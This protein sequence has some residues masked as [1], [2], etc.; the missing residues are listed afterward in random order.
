M[1]KEQILAH[2]K[3]RSSNDGAGL[4]AGL[5]GR[6]FREVFRAV[7]TAANGLR[8][9]FSLCELRLTAIDRQWLC[10]WPAQVSAAALEAALRD[11]G[12]DEGVVPFEAVGLLLLLVATEVGRQFAVSGEIWPVLYERFSRQ[13]AGVIFAGKHPRQVVREAIEAACRRLGLRHAFGI[14]GTQ[15]YYLTIYLQF[16]FGQ[17]SLAKLPL[18][19]ESGQSRPRSVELL[20][21]SSGEFQ[22]LWKALE[23]WV[24][25]RAGPHETEVIRSSPFIPEE[26]ILVLGTGSVPVLQQGFCFCWEGGSI[27]ELL[28]DLGRLYPD[29]ED[30][31]Y[32]VTRLDEQQ[33]VTR[34]NGKFE[35]S[36]LRFVLAASEET[37]VLDPLDASSAAQSECLRLWDTDESYIFLDPARGMVLRRM[38][39]GPFWLLTSPGYRSTIGHS[40][41]SSLEDDWRI[42]EFPSPP[43][44]RFLDGPDGPIDFE[45]TPQQSPLSAADLGIMAH[46]VLT[47][48]D[49]IQVAVTSLK[50][51]AKDCRFAFRGR[52][53][54]AELTLGFPVLDIELPLDLPS[55]E[56]KL[57]IHARANGRACM[58]TVS[59]ALP[60]LAATWRDRGIWKAL[61]GVGEIEADEMIRSPVRLF[62]NKGFYAL[63]EGSTLSH[64]VR[65]GEQFLKQLAGLGRPLMLRS[66]PFHPLE[67]NIVLA[68][69]VVHRGRLRKI[70][71][72]GERFRL[73]LARPLQDDPELFLLW[74]D[75]GDTVIR[76]TLEGFL[77]SKE[78]IEG[79]VPDEL[80]DRPFA[81]ALGFQ[82]ARLGVSWSNTLAPP[83]QANW[84][85]VAH[86]LRWMQ[87]PFLA[88]TWWS[89][90]GRAL[91]ENWWV[92]LNAWLSGLRFQLL[93]VLLEAPERQEF[94]EAIVRLVHRIE[95]DASESERLLQG[96][97]LTQWIRCAPRFVT[98]ML[99]NAPASS[100]RASLF[101][102]FKAQ[103]MRDLDPLR[104]TAHRSL[105]ADE[106]F[107]D[108]LVESFCQDKDDSSLSLALTQTTFAKLAVASWMGE[109]IWHA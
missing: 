103:S 25:G 4:L 31:T 55:A 59:A 63:I 87:L 81:V 46:G 36:V 12:W 95:P 53:L 92:I 88:D 73:G 45:M 106:R 9:P 77:I 84:S 91:R 29:C 76:T 82:C 24:A 39:R 104:V 100:L 108:R 20:L 98:R 34:E 10:S 1:D 93:D 48:P 22:V 43:Q 66:G 86:L 23:A 14:E 41:W 107:I 42:Y 62:M 94:A 8:R 21:N 85:Q 74:W 33:L 105:G 5:G 57:Q 18:W 28:V 89:L 47:L 83:R 68:Q 75:G 37:I 79:R 17:Q 49:K 16:G 2:I 30:N 78:A 65:E 71:V 7:Q 80:L 67:P 101:S 26:W 56:V 99:I 58:K 69:S 61:S 15:A 11:E 44:G 90:W 13:A 96:I 60:L 3:R 70:A 72:S 27:P 38:P 32:L 97:R 50:H 109:R 54:E 6:G 35:P 19:M 102:D 64:S 40:R 52:P 51:P